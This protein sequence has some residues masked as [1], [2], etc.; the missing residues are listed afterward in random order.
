MC[1]ICQT[2]HPADPKCSFADLPPSAALF[3]TG[4]APGSNSTT[5]VISAGDTFQGT[6][7]SASDVDW[8]RI[9]MTAGTV[10]TISMQGTGG[11][12]LQDTLLALFDSSGAVVAQ[13]DD[14]A[15]PTDITSEMSFTATATGSY[16]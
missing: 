11:T 5:Y 4:D 6:I 16:Y 14:R 12:P 3:E 10:Y 15:Y 1:G 9:D 2:L 7:S 8:I 13:N